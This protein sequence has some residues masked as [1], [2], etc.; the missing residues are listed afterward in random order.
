[1]FKVFTLIIALAGSYGDDL[2]YA[3]DYPT[4]Q[5]CRDAGASWLDEAAKP[6]GE[7]MQWDNRR[8]GKFRCWERPKPLSG[9]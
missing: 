1:M 2:T 9:N 7:E 4:L 8:P 3:G 5:D 6:P